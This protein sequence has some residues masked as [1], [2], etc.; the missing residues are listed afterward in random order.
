MAMRSSRFVE[1][2]PLCAGGLHFLS[3]LDAH[4]HI[5]SGI[6]G[7]IYFVTMLLTWRCRNSGQE[8]TWKEHSEQE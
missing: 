3:M 1:L 4:K 5:M 2:P 7:P 8:I 6:P